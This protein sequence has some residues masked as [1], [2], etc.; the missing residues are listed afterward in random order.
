MVGKKLDALTGPNC[1]FSD[2]HSWESMAWELQEP[3]AGV[4]GPYIRLS[5]MGTH[6]PGYGRCRT[7]PE[8]LE[9]EG[10]AKGSG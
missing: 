8:K 2:L 7:H 1:A 6:H 5:S 10:R 4:G 3:G 9:Q